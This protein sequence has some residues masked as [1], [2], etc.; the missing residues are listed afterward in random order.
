MP[1]YNF[2]WS[3][4]ATRY[5]LTSDDGLVLRYSRVIPTAPIQ[6]TLGWEQSNEMYL[7]VLFDANNEV[8]DL[9]VCYFYGDCIFRGFL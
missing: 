9:I 1:P 6:R 2:T 5:N 3:L 7:S 8:C 4:S